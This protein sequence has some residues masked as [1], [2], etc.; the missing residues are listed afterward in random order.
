MGPTASGK[1]D[2]AEALA[3]ELGAQLINADAF[4]VYRGLDVG[5]SKPADPSRYR[6]LNLRDPRE[7]FGVGEFVEL[8]AKELSELFREGR[9]AIVVGGSGLYVRALMEGYREMRPPPDPALRNELNRL[10]EK[11]GVE[12]LVERLRRVD[13]DALARIDVR[14]PA[15]VRRA[16]E[17]ATDIRPT[18]QVEIPNFRRSKLALVPNTEI[19]NARIDS[20][21][22]FMVQNGWVDEVRRL[23][24]EGIPREAP[25]LRAIGYRALYAYALGEASLADA[26]ETIRTETKRF[27]KR[28]RT[29]LRTE[30]G[31]RVLS[32]CTSAEQALSETKKALGCQ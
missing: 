18:I 3:E 19:N 30:P 12:G 6:L 4:Q 22:E 9:D 28:Q 8:A 17:I 29:W 16:I 23:M 27:A 26:I 15:R 20:R 14:N 21:L 1:S 25:G 10:Q 31:L 7:G 11:D 32:G 13:A 2:L 24:G 5:T